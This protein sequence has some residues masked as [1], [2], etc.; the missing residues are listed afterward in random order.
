MEQSGSLYLT[1]DES[2]LFDTNYRYKISIIEI[3]YLTKKG[4]KITIITNLDRFAKELIFDKDILL[5]ILGKKL[6][7]KSGLDKATNNYYL[8]GEYTSKQIKDIL[9]PFIQNYLLCCSCDKP[10][11]NI[12]YKRDKIKQKCKACGSKNYL[13]HCDLDIINVLSKCV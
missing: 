12:K 9:Y 5:R 4:T 2:V 11:V 1:S 7:C 6:S 10:E 8:Q 13:E 3:A